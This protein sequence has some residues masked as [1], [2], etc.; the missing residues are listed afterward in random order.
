MVRVIDMVMMIM[1]RLD[2]WGGGGLGRKLYFLIGFESIMFDLCGV[3][4]FDLRIKR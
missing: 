4:A 1:M 3:L 2:L